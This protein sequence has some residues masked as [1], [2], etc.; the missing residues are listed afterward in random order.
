MNSNEENYTL[1]T[2]LYTVYSV[3]HKLLSIPFFVYKTSTISETRR[4]A[5][6]DDIGELAQ[7]KDCSQIKT[8]LSDTLNI[9]TI[10]NDKNWLQF[11]PGK[12]HMFLPLATQTCKI[13]VIKNFR[14]P[15][16]TK[17]GSCCLDVIWMLPWTW[18]SYRRQVGKLWGEMHEETH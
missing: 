2:T 14:S 13:A 9:L 15:A 5:Y 1:Y 18:L 17:H 8:L 16:R 7:Q 10:H 4:C 3:V 11:N 6:A 12:T